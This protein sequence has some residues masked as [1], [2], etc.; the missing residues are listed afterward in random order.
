MSITIIRENSKSIPTP[1]RAKFERKPSPLAH[2]IE[3][4]GDV[5][6]GVLL[7]QISYRFKYEDALLPLEG[8]TWI[9]QTANCW[10]TETGLTPKQYKRALAILKKERL[11]DVTHAKVRR[12]QRWQTTHI[13]LADGFEDTSPLVPERTTAS[14]PSKAH[15]SVAPAGTDKLREKPTREDNK[16]ALAPTVQKAGEK[17]KRKK[18]EEDNEEKVTQL[19]TRKEIET[20]WISACGAVYP[21]WTPTPFAG[22]DWND[23]RI[24]IEKLGKDAPAIVDAAVANW[25]CFTNALER[26]TGLYNQGNQPN[27]HKLATYADVA[28]NWWRDESPTSSAQQAETVEKDKVAQKLASEQF[29]EWMAAGRDK[30]DERE[31]AALEARRKFDGAVDEVVRT[32]L[33]GGDLTP[34]YLKHRIGG[35][36]RSMKYIMAVREQIRAQYRGQ[37]CCNPM[38]KQLFEFSPPDLPD[39]SER[40]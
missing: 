26:A 23:A 37:P 20:M 15:L 21:D 18:A 22:P 40:D 25:S 31:K 3:I 30:I 4:A 5:N 38:L 35:D 7:S 9:A 8:K 10:C 28:I 14:S 17:R 19:A 2:C 29:R 13:R 1:R 39:R 24:L 33:D 27:L 36:E 34:V 16:E 32:L 12:H 11:I 6:A